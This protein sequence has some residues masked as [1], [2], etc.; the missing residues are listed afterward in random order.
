MPCFVKVQI[1]ALGGVATC[2]K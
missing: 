1:V 2:C